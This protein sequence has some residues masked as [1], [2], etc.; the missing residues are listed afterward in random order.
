MS[1]GFALY[2]PSRQCPNAFGRSMA[3]ESAGHAFNDLR[4]LLGA[5]NVR[6]V[7]GND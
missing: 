3:G 6:I 1:G 5:D 4:A 2:Q 7:Y